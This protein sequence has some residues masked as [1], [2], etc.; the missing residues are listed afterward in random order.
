[1]HIRG[2]L[3]AGEKFNSLLAGLKP[4]LG[5]GVQTADQG[6]GSKVRQRCRDAGCLD[7]AGDGEQASGALGQRLSDLL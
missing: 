1:N 7:I 3:S 6:V 5:Y 2:G 4:L